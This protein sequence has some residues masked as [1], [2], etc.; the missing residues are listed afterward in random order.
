MKRKLE[1]LVPAL[2][3]SAV[4]VV[5]V[6]AIAVA[7]S[8]PAVTTGARSHVSDT[9]AVLNGTINP[10]GSATAYYFE[11]GLT[12]AYGVTSKEHSA[13]RGTKL[14]SVSTTASDL[15]PGTVYHYRLVAAN[16]SGSASGSS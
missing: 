7:A 14:V 10:N 11:W 12:T 15:I 13:G 8:S 6:A 16:G 4:L 9:S 3:L 5:G 1:V 2:L